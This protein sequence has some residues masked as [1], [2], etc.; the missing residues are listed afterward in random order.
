[1][2]FAKFWLVF[3]RRKKPEGCCYRLSA[4]DAVLLIDE[5]MSLVLFGIILFYLQF[6]L[7]SLLLLLCPKYLLAE[8]AKLGSTPHGLLH[9]GV[10]RSCQGAISAKLAQWVAIGWMRNF[11]IGFLKNVLSGIHKLGS[12]GRALYPQRGVRKGEVWI[13]KMQTFGNAVDVTR[14]GFEVGEGLTHVR[15]FVKRFHSL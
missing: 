5:W 13:F 3:V 14:L 15:L 4:T 10:H 11:V 7:K 9:H 12:E 8:L 2:V 6:P 1:M